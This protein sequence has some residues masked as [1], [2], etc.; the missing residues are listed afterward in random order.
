MERASVCGGSVPLH[1]GQPAPRL[2]CRWP[3][4][5]AETI[6]RTGAK[7]FLFDE[8]LTHIGL[9]SRHAAW[10]EMLMV[11]RLK[12]QSSIFVTNEPREAMALN[13]RIAVMGSGR[14]HQVGTLDEL[15]HTPA[16]TFVAQYLNTPPVSLLRGH[17]QATYRQGG[18]LRYRVLCK[19]FSLSLPVRWNDFLQRFDLS[20]LL[21]G[22]C[23]DTLSLLWSSTSS[24]VAGQCDASGDWRGFPSRQEYH[25]QAP[26]A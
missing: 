19:S 7:L 24:R 26:A 10:Q 4:F 1:C 25:A 23:A 2:A 16:D 22:I 11:H 17:V 18:S 15:L 6:L 21:L 20:D 12:N 14:I 8:P 13:Q 5:G 9:K 3:R